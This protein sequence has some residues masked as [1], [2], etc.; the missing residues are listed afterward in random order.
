M[1]IVDEKKGQPFVAAIPKKIQARHLA[2]DQINNFATVAQAIRYAEEHLGWCVEYLPAN[3]GQAPAPHEY[4]LLLTA[5]E[6]SNL[7][8]GGSVRQQLAHVW[9][10]WRSGRSKEAQARS[11]QEAFQNI[12]ATVGAAPLVPAR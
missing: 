6:L 4:V 8:N 3:H 12:A 11:M 7:I 10:D 1:R 5:D 9:Q 2:T